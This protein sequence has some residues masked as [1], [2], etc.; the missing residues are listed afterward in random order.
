MDKDALCF[1][2]NSA[3]QVDFFIRNFDINIFNKLEVRLNPESDFE[4][5]K[6]AS[7]YL[8]VIINKY[9]HDKNYHFLISL[10]ELAI[11]KCPAHAGTFKKIAYDASIM[12]GDVDGLLKFSSDSLKIR[13]VFSLFEDE[14][15]YPYLQKINIKSE[16]VFSYVSAWRGKEYGLGI[17][18]KK[19]KN[20]V[21]DEL[22][23]VIDEFS[24]TNNR[25]IAAEAINL[26]HTLTSKEIAIKKL[27]EYSDYIAPISN[28]D[29][30][31]TSMENQRYSR[32][33]KLFMHYPVGSAI[34]FGTTA[35]ED[36]VFLYL[37]PRNFNVVTPLESKSYKDEDFKFKN[38]FSRL[39]QETSRSWMMIYLREAENR[40]LRKDGLGEF[41]QG[42]INELRLFH[43]IKNHFLETK[44]VHQAKPKWLG[45]Q[46]L[47]IYLPD[48]NIGIEY[49]GAQ[50][51]RPVEFFGGQAA[52]EKQQERDRRKRVLCE[53]NGCTLIEFF[54]GYEDG[55]VISIVE[56]AITEGN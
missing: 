17:H 18:G 47:D 1:D 2:D 19:N 16:W 26:F 28:I 12:E 36:A 3:K 11:E 56:K 53:A 37:Y 51:M 48:H 21:L 35:K 49:Q 44:V 45:R 32:T 39:F 7:K 42:W 27:L 15:I 20:R 30:L 23:N 5:A 10:C 31:N 43:V 29:R 24:A 6:K 33:E 46:S 38:S 54:P 9:L 34:D 14:R 4:L 8:T 25:N 40:V 22:Q 41:G 50:H 55:Y 52:F 13:E